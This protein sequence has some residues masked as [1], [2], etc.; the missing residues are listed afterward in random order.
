MTTPTTEDITTW[1]RKIRNPRL[2]PNR[3]RHRDL[4][5]RLH[6]I[7]RRHTTATTRPD[8]YPAT[9]SSDGTS[10]GGA[11]LT[12]PEAAANQ[13]LEG[14]TPPDID[15]H[16]E[17]ALDLAHQAATSLGALL[18]LLDRIDDLADPEPAPGRIAATCCEP[19]CDDLASPKHAGRCEPCYQWRRRHGGPQAPP[20]P[21]DVIAERSAR[22]IRVN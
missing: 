18:A 22:R 12:S 7:A 20:V 10:R 3:D 11:E 8:G 15:R 19:H 14:W 21:R 4:E 13:L 6:D 16:L 2:A 17:R 9:T 1:V 5:A